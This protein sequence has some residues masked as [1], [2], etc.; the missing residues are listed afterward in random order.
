MPVAFQL[1]DFRA[2]RGPLFWLR[3]VNLW[4][5]RRRFLRRD[6]SNEWRYEY[7]REV[8]SPPPPP[9]YPSDPDARTRP[10]SWLLGDNASAVNPQAGFSCVILGDTGEG[11]ASQ[12]TLLPLL[13]ALRPDLVIINGDV[14]Y[15]AGN[16]EDFVEGFFEPYRDLGIPFWAVPGNHEYYSDG[17]GKEFFEVFCS[18]VQA[19]QWVRYGLVP[20][21]QPGSYWELAEPGI[22]L[23]ILGV[24]SGQ[25]GGLDGSSGFLGLFKRDPDPDQHQWLEWRLQEAERRGDAVV[26][27]F[28]FPKLVNGKGNDVGLKRL[29]AIMGR[30]PCIKLVVTAH[31]HNM[32]WYDAA[33]FGR[34]L[35]TLSGPG[36]PARPAYVVSG[37]GGATI[38]STHFD[39]PYHTTQRYPAPREFDEYATFGAK[40]VATLRLSKTIAGDALTGLAGFLGG[41]F[42]GREIAGDA[43]QMRLQSLLH[44]RYLPGSGT[45]VTPYYIRDLAALYGSLPPGTTV[46]VQP[47]IPS[48]PAADLQ[49]CRMAPQLTL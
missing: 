47:G 29:H 42:G 39:G 41:V 9:G 21:P 43:D 20:K 49:A 30:H 11:D 31:V 24:D 25:T 19:A 7:L 22:P 45:V 14:A 34:Y 35:A 13:R 3:P 16:A 28:H 10:Y 46:Q 36:G 48:L 23:T 8:A 27:L 4:V 15:P 6:Y 32:Q 37:S 12:Y 26:V 18:T 1:P 5:G 2:N 17:K 40:L 38:S 33:T 44:L